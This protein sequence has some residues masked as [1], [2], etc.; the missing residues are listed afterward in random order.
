M[1]SEKMKE[2]RAHYDNTSLA[3]EI[4]EAVLNTETE[5][6]PMIGI[7]VRFPKPVLDRVRELAAKEN[8]KTTALVRRWVE[9][10]VNVA[11]DAR[12]HY[13]APKNT[14]TVTVTD[15]MTSIT[16]SRSGARG[17]SGSLAAIAA[18]RRTPLARAS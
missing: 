10:R 6:S 9:E 3:K 18:A 5:A 13:E 12:S 16:S 17:M 11:D 8:I 7:T 14:G 1:D 4:A 2:L 15:S